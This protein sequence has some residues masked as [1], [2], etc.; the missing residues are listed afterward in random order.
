MSGL[1]QINIRFRAELSEFE[2]EM[3]RA[4]R[5]LKSYGEDLKKTGKALSTYLTA[6]IAAFGVTS[7]MAAG[8]FEA[9]MKN[10][11]AIT[12]ATGADLQK[13]NDTAKEMGK[14]TVFSASQAADAMAFLGMAGFNT[15]EIIAA[16][17][18]V[19]SLAAAGNLELARAADIASNIMGQF[20]IAAEDTSRVTNVLAATAASANT[21]V[22]QL[23]QAMVYLGPTAASLGMSVEDTAGIIAVL[24][25]AGI[26][27]SMAG[28]A[29]GSA[30]VRLA[31]PTQKI[32]DAMSNLGLQVFDAAGNFVGMQSFLAQVEKGLQGMTQE[33]KAANLSMLLGA[34]AFQEINILLDRGSTAY[35]DYVESITATDKATEMAATKMQGLNAV[36]KEIASAFE[37]LQIR[38]AESGLL[39]FATNLGKSIASLLREIA[40]LNPVILK[41]VTVLGGVAAAA[42]PVLYALGFLSSTV[43]PGIIS[44]ITVLTGVIAAN[45]IGALAVGATAAAAAFGLFTTETKE[46]NSAL[47]AEQAE[48][49]GLVMA[50]QQSTA[51][52][53]VRAGLIDELQKKY[54]SFLKSLDIERATNDQL[55]TAL[56]Q[57]N[58]EYEKRM[59]LEGQR[60]QLTDAYTQSAEKLQAVGRTRLQLTKKLAEAEKIEG[61]EIKRNVSTLEAAQDAVRQISE[62]RRNL[63]RGKSD[64]FSFDDFAKTQFAL[65]ELVAELESAEAAYSESAQAVIDLKNEQN[66]LLENIEDFTTKTDENAVGVENATLSLEA[67]I[68]KVEELK[69]AQKG[70]AS[71]AEYDELQTQIDSL[72]TSIEA[73]APTAEVLKSVADLKEELSGLKDVQETVTNPEQWDA[74]QKKIDEVQSAIDRITSGVRVEEIKVDAPD[75]RGFAQM[76]QSNTAK[77]RVIDYKELDWLQDM[78]EAAQLASEGVDDLANSANGLKARQQVLNEALQ[79]AIK[80]YG[81]NSV[82][83]RTLA[84]SLRRVSADLNNTAVGLQ[85]IRGLATTMIQSFQG[86]P[87]RAAE[88]RELEARISDL[89][90]QQTGV[91]SK[92]E[93]DTLQEEIAATQGQI[94]ELNEQDPFGAFL[95]Y[96]KNMV[97]ELLSAIAVAALL[98]VVLAGTGLGAFLGMGSNVGQVFGSLLQLTTGLDVGG[99]DRRSTQVPGFAAGA[100]V[101]GPTLAVIGEGGQNEYVL[102]EGKM[103][104]LINTVAAIAGRNRNDS[105]DVNVTG[106]MQWEGNQVSVSVRESD[107]RKKIWS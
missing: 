51:E 54:P 45:P 77:I 16:I 58:K 107:K 55:Q 21:N 52:E 39:E 43:I 103:Q 12:G 66:S 29:L 11:E 72:T 24:G 20:G 70:V 87:E 22:E 18:D 106:S 68:Q 35:S 61:V 33:Q 36:G 46:L 40:D 63:A 28:R 91:S 80:T 71:Q 59:I 26:Q 102:P 9:A 34:E 14:T 78:E 100:Y 74:Y 41:T 47:A 17:P 82:S 96:L 65:S 2:R 23:A 50:I 6:P 37:F 81:E 8:N 105:L 27:G 95:G 57:V 19:L 62:V 1:A 94:N 10:V 32:T 92:K 93:W 49:N 79:V 104:G 90:E 53:R 83:A 73:V 64:S 76:G 75:K 5:E 25:D 89:K 48:L 7:L 98:S 101:T 44:G 97:A 42:G 56:D 84:A 67:M 3:K 69:A 15:Q 85:A 86:I 31:D 88:I 30:L 99:G 4:K 60:K 38:I 13:L